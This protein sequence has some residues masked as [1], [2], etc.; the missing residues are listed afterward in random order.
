[1]WLFEFNLTSAC[2]LG[3]LYCSN[4]ADAPT[5]GAMAD[6]RVASAFVRRV[7]DYAAARG[8]ASLS[9]EF[10]GGEP[11]L[12]FTVM[13]QTM[14][15][16][17]RL[18][19]HLQVDW[20]I[21]TNFTAISEEALKFLR[22]FNPRIGV[23]WDGYQEVQDRQRPFASGR[24]SHEKVLATV[25][26]AREAGL[27]VRAAYCVL[28][29]ESVAHMTE[30]TQFLL[31]HDMLRLVMEPVRPSGRARNKPQLVPDPITY[32]QQLLETCLHVILP[33][34]RETGVLVAERHLTLTLA[35]LMEPARRYMCSQAPC[36]AGRLI[37]STLPGG[38]VYPCNELPWPE[39]FRLGNVLQDGFAEMAASEPAQR[40]RQRT[41]DKIEGCRDCF[42]RG[43]CHAR[44]SQG[45][46][47]RHGKLLAPGFCCEFEKALCDVFLGALADGR[48][49]PASARLMAN[50]VVGCI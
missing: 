42:Y 25:N 28:T 29:A 7:V 9:V 44:C 40:L 18:A 49:D 23:S 16:F 50:D 27:E 45:A 37:S 17:S 41:P 12:N 24:G 4:D 8:L 19:P 34:Y 2:N 6:S 46:L 47:F 14:E 32:A 15:D 21:Q 48:L 31:G 11:F 13:R 3:C 43:W 39:D 20:L 33:H 36:G 22:P 35:H 26:R 38:W 10:T 1:M 30:I 5:A